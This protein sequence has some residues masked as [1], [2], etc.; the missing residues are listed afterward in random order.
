MLKVLITLEFEHDDTTR[1]E[2]KL[3]LKD[4]IEDDSIN[5]DIINTEK[6]VNGK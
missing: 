3:Y 4:L 6:G 5:Y 1:E 2:I